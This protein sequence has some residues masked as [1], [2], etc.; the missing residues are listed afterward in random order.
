MILDSFETIKKSVEE[1]DFV[2]VGLGE[3][4]T[5][6][7]EEFLS[8]VKETQPKLA[9]VFEL[10]LSDPTYEQLIPYFERVL[11]QQFIPTKWKQAYTNLVELIGNK[12]YYVVSLTLD[13]YLKD[14]GLNPEKV[15]NPCGNYKLLQCSSCGGELLIADDYLKKCDEYVTKLMTGSDCDSQE[16]IAAFLRDLQEKLGQISCPSC[17][18]ALEFNNITAKCYNEAGYLPDWQNYMKW[19]TMTVNKKVCIIEAGAG[20]KFPSVIRWPFEK[21]TLYNQKAVMYRIHHN[22]HQVNQEIADRSYGCKMNAVDLM[23]TCEVV[24]MK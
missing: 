23:T 6:P 5:I 17:G 13:T 15:V 4:W 12:N 22:Y 24:E 21:T 18:N 3:E 1:S 19:L 20:M 7:Y 9:P 16:E 11:Y 10:V 8:S 2:L 14:Q